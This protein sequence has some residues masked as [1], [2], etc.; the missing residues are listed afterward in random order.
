[1]VPENKIQPPKQCARAI[2]VLADEVRL[3]RDEIR[4]RC[5][6]VGPT[7]NCSGDVAPVTVAVTSSEIVLP[8]RPVVRSSEQADP[9]R[10]LTRTLKNSTVDDVH[11]HAATGRS[12][13]IEAI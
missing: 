13:A 6:A 12:V 5:D 1:M 2:G 3:Q 9:S 4:I 10:V 8:D 11:Q 7:K